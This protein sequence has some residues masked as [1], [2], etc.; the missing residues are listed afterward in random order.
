[1]GIWSWLAGG[2]TTT[3]RPSIRIGRY[4]DCYKK[5][6]NYKAWELSLQAFE[7]E[8]Y[9]ESFRQFFNYL[10]DES[11]KN[12]SWSEKNKGISAVLI[13]G[14]QKVKISADNN[15]FTAFTSIAKAEQLNIGLMRRLLE[16]NDNLLY[17]HFAL[18]P[19]NEIKVVF[20]SNSIDCSPYKLYFALKELATIS[21]KQDNLLLD[22]FTNLSI[23]DPS[24]R[25][26]LP[27][28]EKEQKY[29][30]CI[31]TLQDKLNFI[32]D[33]KIDFDLHSKAESY[34]LLDALFRI[35]YLICPEG[36]VMEVIERAFRE[37]SENDG[38]NLLQKNYKLKK[39]IQS[40]LDRPKV[41]HLHE[42]YDISSTFGI[43]DVVT[44]D[45]VVEVI[46]EHLINGDWYEK[47]GYSQIAQSVYNYIVGFIFFTSAVPKNIKE[48][49]RL[50]FEVVEEKYFNSFGYQLKFRKD[51]G[52]INRKEIE[53]LL[54]EIFHNN[55]EN[56]PLARFEPRLVNFN[57]I[58]EFSKSF[59]LM[60]TKLDMSKTK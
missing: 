30:Y 5:R 29:N 23:I 34:W 8:E 57:N 59:L 33:S 55:M 20:S 9:L 19:E 21:D 41:P 27:D 44:F 49:L 38:S 18:S 32:L 14:S 22:E 28:I 52:S 45:R 1:M 25:I 11:Q 50:Y 47:N 37:F 39:E 17:G 10:S 51:D 54:A 12:I 36:F 46:N 60:I 42:L 24:L 15:R 4:S 43:T 40:I 13:Q 2:E 35:D 31:Q 6:E 16:H 3:L 53:R 48:A 26:Q 56:F 58:T 7:K